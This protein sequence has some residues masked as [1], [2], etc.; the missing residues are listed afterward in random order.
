MVIEVAE[1]CEAWT[2]VLPD[3][4][5]L[6][7]ESAGLALARGVGAT[8][9]SSPTEGELCIVFVDDAEQRKLNREWRGIDQP[10]NVLAFPAW[11]PDRRLPA[12]APFLLGDVVLAYETVSCEANGQ[13]KPLADHV[14]HLV[15]HGVLH[16]LGY[17]H[18]TEQ[19]AVAMEQ[20]E[21]S[22]LAELGVAD[23][24]RFTM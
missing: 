7:R 10:T 11:D 14:R 2:E 20:L 21:T 18:L 3:A 22:I 19:E 12:D 24:Y 6:A 23:P 1:I 16:L 15:I 17:D 13:G 4:A 8:A 5:K 9:L